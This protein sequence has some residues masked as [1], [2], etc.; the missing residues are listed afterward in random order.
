MARANFKNRYT[1]IHQTSPHKPLSLELQAL[2][3]LNIQITILDLEPNLHL[4]FYPSSFIRTSTLIPLSITFYQGLH[5]IFVES[6]SHLIRKLY[7]AQNCICDSCLVCNFFLY[8]RQDTI[9][10]NTL[11]LLKCNISCSSC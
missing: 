7:M 8:M 3:F 2:F 9:L 11:E 6:S 4:Q 1:Y 5:F 10:C